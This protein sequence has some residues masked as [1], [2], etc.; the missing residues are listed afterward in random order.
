MK[1]TWCFVIGLFFCVNFA[2][3]CQTSTVV[4]A[5]VMYDHPF[6]DNETVKTGHEGEFISLYN[7]DEE[8]VDISGWRIEITDMMVS[9]Q[10]QYLYT[11]PA[12]TIL[13]ESGMAIIA[14]RAF[15]SNFNVLQFYES[16][17]PEETEGYFLLYT[18]TL[19]FPDTRTRI[20]LYD[21]Q[22]TIQDE[23]VYDGESTTL[24]NESPLRAKNTANLLRPRTETVSIQREKIIVKEGTRVISRTDYFAPDPERTVMLFNYIPEDYSYTAPPSLL[25]AGVPDDLT[26]SG[27]ASGTND[28]RSKTITSNQVIESGTTQYWTEEEIVLGP[29]F[30]VKEGAEFVAGVERDSVHLVKMMTYNL[31]GNHTEYKKHAQVVKNANPDV[32]AVQEV[33]KKHKFKILKDSSGYSGDMKIT[34]GIIQYGIGL[35]WNPAIVGNPIKKSYQKVKTK[36]SFWEKNRAYMVAAFHDFC[37]VSTHY[38]L[39]KDGREK[40]SQKILENSLVTQCQNEGKPVYIAGDLNEHIHDKAALSILEEGGYE[41][42]N[43]KDFIQDRNKNYHYADSTKADG[44]M[45]DFIYEYN[46]NPYHKTMERGVPIPAS[47]RK[48]F[49]ENI[50]DHLPY[51]VRVKI[52]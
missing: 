39:K 33:R 13:P 14:S 24:S 20:R 18:L 38:S 31:R 3:W 34:V 6:Y 37:F 23:L 30:E 27:T 41:L 17:M 49:F 28:R 16:E 2:A 44:A 40:M 9:P 10:K 1:T 19:A 36:D 42:L 26:L 32:V 5:E 35:L 51:R 52:K 22:N 29:G 21:A 15:N 11:I 7:Y 12:N 25:S 47:Q 45:I 50:S 8:D 46:K 43:N 4:I 48:Q